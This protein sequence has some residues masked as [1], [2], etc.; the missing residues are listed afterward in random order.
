MHCQ[1]YQGGRSTLVADCRVHVN[2]ASENDPVGVE[3]NQ[4]T[5]K[6]GGE[7]A[8]ANAFGEID[9]GGLH[10]F[11]AIHKPRGTV[12]QT[13]AMLKKHTARLEGSIA[14]LLVGWG[15]RANTSKLSP[16]KEALLKKK[17]LHSRN[18]RE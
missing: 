10:G 11:G 14:Y 12:M 3:E 4:G 2:S 9:E 5:R 18:L 13:E 16:S 6:S 17:T 8:A 7:K 15:D 1:R